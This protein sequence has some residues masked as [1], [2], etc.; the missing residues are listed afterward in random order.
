MVGGQSYNYALRGDGQLVT[1]IAD[2]NDQRKALDALLNTLTPEELAISE[3]ILKIIPPRALGYSRGREN[4]NVRTGLT[5]DPLGAAETAANMTVSFIFHPQR[6]ARLIEYHSRNNSYPGLVEV[7]D[8]VI[9]NT[10]KSSRKADYH[11]EI[12]NVVDQAVLQNLMKMAAHENASSRTKSISMFKLD[13]LKTWL[14]EQL[15]R[16]KDDSQKAH[17]KMAVYQIEQFQKNPEDLKYNPLSPPA[18]SPIGM[19]IELY[20]C[21]QN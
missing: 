15:I 5:F 6:S 21:D 2:G 8:K 9:S 11:G 7:I 17:Y 18:G 3:N 19:G 12:Q 16:V 14:Q 4:F 10:W 1:E 13:E 20:G